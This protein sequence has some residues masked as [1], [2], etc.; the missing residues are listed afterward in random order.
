MAGAV[1]PESRPSDPD[2]PGDA[3]AEPVLDAPAEDP[4]AWAHEEN[5]VPE[6][7][8]DPARVVAVLVAHQAGDWLAR[9]LVAL[10]RLEPRPG[11]V[12]AV[13]TGSTD[14]TG[15]L[16]ERGRGEGLVDRIV[17]LPADTAFADAV[18]RGWA[19]SGA[20]DD[21]WLWILHDDCEPTRTS[22]GAL[23]TEAA[24][25]PAP[26]AVVP[27]LL[28]P[29]RRNRPDR[30]QEVGQSISM[31]GSRLTASD[32]DEINQQQFESQQVLG[33][34]TAGLLV[35]GDLMNR[36]GGLR[37]EF[38]HREGID[39]CWRA[40][41]EGERTVTAPGATVHHRRAGMSGVRDSS[42]DPHPAG[43]DRLA[44]MRLI[45]S[46]SK[47]RGWA[48][49][50]L[51]LVCLGR[52]LGLLLGRAPREAAAEWRAMIAFW[53]T[54]GVT[55]QLAASISGTHLH[56][57]DTLRPHLVGTLREFVSAHVSSVASRVVD[58]RQSDTSLEELIGDD[59]TATPTRR[60][61]IPL[62]VLGVVLA[63][64]GVAAG[65]RLLGGNLV[66]A[67]LLPTP[68]LGQL[69]TTW[70]RPESGVAG[71]SAPWLF[72]AALGSTL[73]VGHAGVWVWAV[74]AFAVAVAG[75]SALRLVD[76][77]TEHEPGSRHAALSVAV[78]VAYGVMLLWSGAVQRGSVGTVAILATAPWFALAVHR[79]ATSDLEGPAAW[80]APAAAALVATLWVSVQ[81]ATWVLVLLAAG[82]VVL[83]RH[84][85]WTQALVPILAP[86]VFLAG[87]WVRLIDQP[88][89]LLTTADP[90]ADPSGPAGGALALVGV[91]STHASLPSWLAIA[92]G[93]LIWLVILVG[94]LLRPANLPGPARLAGVV[95][96]VGVAVGA[97]L[98]R[99][100]LTLD[101]QVVR[102]DGTA[103]VVLGMG[104]LLVLA[105]LGLDDA[106]P[107]IA[108]PLVALLVV[109]ALGVAAGA[110]VTSNR[111]AQ[112]A[113]SQLPTWVGALQ[114]STRAGRAL[115]VDLAAHPVR[116]AVT[117]ARH[118]AWGSGESAGLLSGDSGAQ[119]RSLAVEIASGHPSE[120]LAD[121][122]SRVG[123]VAVWVHG[124]PSILGG[125]PGLQA[126]PQNADTTVYGVA[127]LVSRAEIVDGDQVQ[128]VSN[129]TIAAAATDRTLV[130]AEPRDSRLRAKVGSTWLSPTT[131]SD[132][133][134]AYD[135]P[136]GVSGPLVWDTRIQTWSILLQMLVLAVL[137]VSLAP[138]ASGHDQALRRAGLAPRRGAE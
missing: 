71:A 61:H 115:M 23:L 39:L 124:D 24:R 114:D 33:G 35:R 96:A 48:G 99:I 125:V 100:P 13:D 25:N 28:R 42:A 50:G 26:A 130:I 16:L 40:R 106:G 85:A 15:E 55:A 38:P 41:D 131:G 127:G 64:V 19:E 105:R 92:A 104:L 52:V 81:P 9:T 95:G 27:A 117:D 116:W 109:G 62:A 88:A 120:D 56:D 46:R 68:Q 126:T 47:H 97:W 72:W 57:G 31:A 112:R 118:P 87:W 69:W 7:M 129:G 32:P 93:A 58:R 78:A 79:W 135:L 76:A 43:A 53:R 4:W 2:S 80:R 66:S 90:A 51:T 83:G 3:D 138:V 111:P 107:R 49:V 20:S 102:A 30:I 132:W 101:G 67:Q 36:L 14:T 86:L 75:W 54:R 91:F 70:A 18:N 113:P 136:A 77:V 133:R 134:Q 29:R 110:I 74:L 137:L 37:P 12:V 34:A 1:R 5:D 21:D 45:A 108:R 63:L 11:T 44:G 121:S 65:I 98:P 59:F 128:P 94:V 73:A 119:M 84:S 82:V 103:F 122:L 6:P 8:V 22:L 123:I 89:R 60:R 17:D 10:G